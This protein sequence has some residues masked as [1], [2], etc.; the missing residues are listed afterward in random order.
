[1]VIKTRRITPEWGFF[2]GRCHHTLIEVKE[3]G[4]G[5]TRISIEG[6]TTGVVF[7]PLE[8]SEA[9]ALQFEGRDVEVLNVIEGA[10][11]RRIAREIR[12]YAARYRDASLYGPWPGPNSNTFV[13]RLARA[14]PGLRLE[15]HHNAMCKD[16]SWFSEFGPTTTGTGLELETPIAG[17]Q[18]GL[19]EGLELHLLALTFGVGFYPFAIKLPFLPR[20]GWPL[21]AGLERYDEPSAAAGR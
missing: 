5:W 15:Q 12:A 1:M 9:Y 2:V 20:I 18:V 13:D 3:G 8:D 11:A 17:V 10:E 21:S 7:R 6:D 16:F 4:R 19:R 14:V